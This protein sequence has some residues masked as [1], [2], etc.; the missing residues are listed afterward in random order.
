MLEQ[1]GFKGLEKLKVGDQV[2][3]RTGEG[4]W[5]VEAKA[6]IIGEPGT[7]SIFIRLDSIQLLGKDAQQIL[8]LEVG[9]KVIAL[10]SELYKGG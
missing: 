2:D 7:A 6:T 10:A 5:R 3:Y 4:D 1:V 8:G 9:K